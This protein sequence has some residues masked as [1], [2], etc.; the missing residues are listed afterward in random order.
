LK[1]RREVLDLN[2]I[3]QTMGE[4]QPKVVESLKDLSSE[5]IVS[6]IFKDRVPYYTMQ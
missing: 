4:L 6:R 2:E 5:G 3:V 1:N